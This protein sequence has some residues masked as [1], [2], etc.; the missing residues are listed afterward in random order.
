MLPS[1]CF[2]STAQIGQKNPG[3]A[4]PD[5]ARYYCERKSCYAL[6]LMAI[7]DQHRRILWWDI[8]FC[9]TTH[10]S[11][12]WADTELGR[13]INN[14]GLPSPF[15]INGDNAFRPAQEWMATPG[16]TDAYDFVQSSMRMPIECGE[17]VRACPSMLACSGVGGGGWWEVAVGSA[18]SFD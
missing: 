5:P 15:F 1:P 4:V 6:L 12:A 18:V 17:S 2:V 10:D 8:S 7:A 16:G 14:G 9:P 3:K 13:R 11:T